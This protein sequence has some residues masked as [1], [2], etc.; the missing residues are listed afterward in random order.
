MKAMIVLFLI[1]TYVAGGFLTAAHYDQHV[2][3]PCY[4]RYREDP[5]K[6]SLMD[7]GIP[8]FVGFV[9]PGYWAW[10]GALA[11]TR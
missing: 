1:A 10:R 3:R 8:P 2:Y 7:C 11:V 9:W 5:L 6:S 4:D